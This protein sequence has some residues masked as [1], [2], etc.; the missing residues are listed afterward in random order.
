M[1]REGINGRKVGGRGKEKAVRGESRK[2][3][4]FREAILVAS[5]GPY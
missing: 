3:G 5:W 4:G 1:G 2:G